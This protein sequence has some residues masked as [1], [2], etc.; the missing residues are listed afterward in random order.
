MEGS[1]VT[2]AFARA[3]KQLASWRADNPERRPAYD[4]WPAD[5]LGDTVPPS[6][7]GAPLIGT[8]GATRHLL[9][10]GE[11]RS[12]DLVERSLEAIKKHNDR[13]YAFVEI[14]EVEARERA[15]K[16]DNEMRAGRIRG[17]LH[18]IPISV[19]D[20]I[21][22]KGATTRA[23]SLAY[24]QRASKDAWAV[25]RLRDAGA[26][27]LG[28]SATHEFALGVSSAQSRNP[29]D[30][31]RIT[32]GSSGGSAVAVATGMGI[33]SL[34][35]ETR[36]STRVPAA[37][38]G[39]VGLKPTYGTIPTT[40]IVPLAWTMDHFGI[41]APSVGDAAAMLDA[42]D[43]RKTVA[44]AIALGVAGMTLGAPHAAWGSVA[45]DVDGS[46]RVAL[47][48]LGAAG[49]EVV[50]V[51]TP[52]DSDFDDASAAA[53]IISRCEAASFHGGLDGDRS[54]YWPEVRDQLDAADGVL[55]TDYI[56]AQRYRAWLRERMLTAI[57]G[58]DA[59]VMPASPVTA[60]R[61]DEADEY[62]TVLSRN[63][64]LWSFVGF[65]AMSVPTIPAPGGLPVGVQIVAAPH[66]E[67]TM[68]A[69][70]R[71]VERGVNAR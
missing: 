68:I 9:D 11:L 41:L 5:A 32:G 43:D 10:S 18:G 27:I 56:D 39:V 24:E 50:E 58:V 66:A 59:L 70:G 53:L 13:L 29:H 48:T 64:I 67:P 30:D 69:V 33:A 45:A 40:G 23:G 21:H 49:A 22:V 42:L 34:A 31:E 3:L 71:A 1:V 65:P 8:I 15:A 37:V 7:N 14:L 16:L 63:A 61:V 4:V 51:D 36:A 38:C 6:A 26:I 55:A 17:P 28:K 25:K 60:P 2:G 47:D 20:V 44:R 57:A 12:I 54:S 35:T 62:L 46:V 19:K 52:T